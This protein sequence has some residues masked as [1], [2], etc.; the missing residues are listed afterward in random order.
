MHTVLECRCSALPDRVHVAIVADPLLTGGGPVGPVL[1]RLV[2]A[3][4]TELHV[5]TGPIRSD[6]P[7]PFAARRGLRSGGRVAALLPAAD[8]H[9]HSADVSGAS[10]AEDPLSN[11]VH[12]AAPAQ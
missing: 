5:A 7:C 2:S 8:Q 12:E 3:M 6:L 4:A 11:Q 9:L 1:R 10:S